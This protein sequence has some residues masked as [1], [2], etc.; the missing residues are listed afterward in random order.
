[1]ERFHSIE[2]QPQ[3]ESR[4]EAPR[5]D[6]KYLTSVFRDAKRVDLEL[7]KEDGQTPWQDRYADFVNQRL[8]ET[9]GDKIPEF[10]RREDFP[11]FLENAEYTHN[12]D[13]PEYFELVIQDYI[14]GRVHEAHVSE[15]TDSSEIPEI[16]QRLDDFY[17]K[18]VHGGEKADSDLAF[19][20]DLL[21]EI[22]RIHL[23][24]QEER[25][26]EIP[27]ASWYAAQL[28]DKLNEK[29]GAQRPLTKEIIEKALV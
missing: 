12:A 7:Q 8:E 6:N 9:F 26:K 18:I 27:W 4:E 21:K 15:F 11:R 10:F 16:R 28:E 19:I 5:P 14:N 3:P 24:Y 25:A 23:Q 2:D 17:L 22:K 13:W 1:M 20:A 29:F